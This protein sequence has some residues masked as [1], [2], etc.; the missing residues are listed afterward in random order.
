MWSEGEAEHFRSRLSAL[1]GVEMGKNVRSRWGTLTVGVA[2]LVALTVIPAIGEEESASPDLIRLHMGA[3]ADQ[4]IHESAGSVSDTQDLVAGKQCQLVT[5]NSIVSVSA[6]SRGAGIVGDS[7]GVRSSGSNSSGTPCSRISTGETL[8]LGLQPGNATAMELDLE[9]KGSTSIDVRVND[10]VY[11]VQSGSDAVQP[12]GGW[13]VASTNPDG[14]LEVALDP[15]QRNGTCGRLSDSGPDAGAADN[16]RIVITPASSFSSVTLAGKVGDVSLE[17]GGDYG[18]TPD[19]R[20]ET[21]FFLQGFDGA[22]ACADDPSTPE[23]ENSTGFE[24]EDGADTGS[25]ND[26]EGEITRYENTDGSECIP[27][28]Y[29]LEVVASNPDEGGVPTL[30]FEVEDPTSGQAAIYRTTL[31]FEQDMFAPLVLLYDSDGG[32]GYDDY[33]TAP[34]CVENPEDLSGDPTGSLNDEAIPTGH[35]ACVVSVTQ[36]W[37]GLTTWDVIFQGD[38]RFK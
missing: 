32:D 3:D 20:Y 14:V 9:L 25:V 16:C 33:K 36:T 17:G 19:S 35:E 18:P 4:F 15:G 23:I 21:L 6:N 37:D 13:N 10:E 28:S 31:V 29:T 8:T 22:L 24:G 12:S 34:A 26:L 5:D 1:G 11:N 2:V 7:L 27:K 30:T 38:W